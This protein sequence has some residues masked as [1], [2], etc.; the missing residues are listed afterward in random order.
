MNNKH[1]HQAPSTHPQAWF[2]EPL[3]SCGGKIYGFIPMLK[4]SSTK[5]SAS[6]HQRRKRIATTWW[7]K[8]LATTVH[9]DENGLLVQWNMV[10]VCRVV[11]EASDQD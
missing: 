4:Y 7:S 8:A 6:G 5:Q 3:K 2:E 9:N 10:A 11:T 1:N